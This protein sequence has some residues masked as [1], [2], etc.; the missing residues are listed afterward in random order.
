MI[1]MNEVK[2]VESKGQDLM[3]R[4]NQLEIER[5]SLKNELSVTKHSLETKIAAYDDVAKKFRDQLH[6]MDDIEKQLR[7]AERK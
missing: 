7:S 4:I 1:L 6:N 3:I 2:G 5:D